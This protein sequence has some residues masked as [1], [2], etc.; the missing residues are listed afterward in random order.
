MNE[1]NDKI[2]LKTKIDMKVILLAIALVV[3]FTMLIYQNI[4]INGL[5][6][7][8]VLN[9][10]ENVERFE[11][12]NKAPRKELIGEVRKEFFDNLNKE[13]KEMD[14]MKQR[15]QDEMNEYFDGRDEEFNE[16]NP[17]VV[18]NIKNIDINLKSEEEYDKSKKVYMMIV[19]LPK[20]FDER[21]VDVSI[22]KGMLYVKIAKNEKI[23]SKSGDF[24]DNF[25]SLK[26]ISLPS[27]KATTKDIKKTFE[28]GKLK[29]IVPIM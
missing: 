20:N 16:E 24:E 17:L 3:I 9:N 29:I 6:K 2:S 8:I 26:I 21:N 5:T 1:K 11:H 23:D 15:V 7:H 12:K 10:I 28:D 18:N 13:I 25:S 27:T 14:S 4:K 22:D 19:Y